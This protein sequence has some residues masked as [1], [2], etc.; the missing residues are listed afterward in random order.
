MDTFDHL[1]CALLITDTAGFA[2]H[3]NHELLTLMG[4]TQTQLCAQPIA[5]LLTPA[6]RIFLQTHVWPMLLRTER[7]S[8][9]YLHLC[10]ATQ[11]R[12]PVMVNCQKRHWMGA[13]CYFWIMFVAKERSRFEAELLQARA[14]A[15]Q[16]SAHLAQAH[17]EL[18]ALHQQLE[19]RSVVIQTENRELTDLSRTD[20]L[21]GLA[22]RRALGLSVDLWRAQAPPEANAALLMV[23]VDH[24][25]AVNDRHGHPEGDRVLQALANQLKHSMRASD[26]AVRYG[27]EEFVMWLPLADREGADQAARRVHANVRKVQV[28]GKSI[29]V[30][31]GIATARNTPGLDLLQVL[32]QSADKALYEAKATGRNRSVHAQITIAKER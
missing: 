17:T 18:K 31:I 22:N 16:M 5:T 27:G 7:I 28:A 8:E 19:Q 15:Q 6:S 10:D 24:F 14:Q 1:P 29:T 23:D 32:S 9:I 20:T 21:T 30:S 4:R 26:L 12:I 3:A 2:A 11:Q 13:E 25:K